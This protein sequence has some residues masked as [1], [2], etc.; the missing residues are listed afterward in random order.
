M[1]EK[2]RRAGLWRVR[3]IVAG[4]AVGI[5]MGALAGP[6]PTRADPASEQ[7]YSQ[8][9]V[10]EVGGD[11]VVLVDVSGSLRTGNLY[12]ALR[13]GLRGLFAALAPKD[14]VTVVTFAESAVQVWRG[15]AGDSPDAI[16]AKL[17]PVA[18]GAYTDIGLALE[19]AVQVLQRP[20]APSIGTLIMLTDGVHDPKPGSRYPLESGYAWDQLTKSAAG[21]TKETFSAYAIP[22]A[23]NTSAALLTK[24]FGPN[25]S[26]LPTT[27]VDQIS[28]RLAEPKQRVRVAKAQGLLAADLGRDIT[29]SWPAEVSRLGVGVSTLD[30]TLQS[31][32]EHLPTTVSDLGVTTTCVGRVRPRVDGRAVELPPGGAAPVQ[33]VVEWDAGPTS[34]KP[35]NTV[36]QECGLTLT[37]RVGTPWASYL[38]DELRV[39]L[40]AKIAGTDTTASFSTQRGSLGWW[41]AGFGLL[42]LLLTIGLLVRWHRLHPMLDGVLSV[43][44]VGGS[45]ESGQTV[46]IAGDSIALRGRRVTISAATL[47]IPG[48]G[49][50]R[51]LRSR[52]TSRSTELE[53]AYSRDGSVDAREVGVCPPGGSATVSKTRFEWRSADR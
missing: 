13:A 42:V 4:L 12:N 48:A 36:R 31:Q 25:T 8:L 38:A 41:Q 46:G 27:N 23:G 19:R 51:G 50:V 20:D 49:T 24:V 6:V 21:L 1:S 33:L 18:D 7:I 2:G 45:G 15:P 53:I 16:V 35:S 28:A 5:C 40:T 43:A 47:G 34:W 10:Q 14:E 9:G 29:V 17:P 22:L 11:Y 52:A 30:V 44:S 32:N 37:G 26:I 3:S 39:P